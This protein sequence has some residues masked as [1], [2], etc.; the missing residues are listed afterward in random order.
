MST[1]E[2]RDGFA[3][4]ARTAAG[5][6]AGNHIL[7]EIWNEPNTV[8]FWGSEANAADYVEL[9]KVAAPGIKEADPTGLV[10][11]PCVSWLDLDWIEDCFQNGLLEWIDALSVHLYRHNYESPETAFADN[12]TQSNSL[13]TVRE[14]IRQYAPTGKENIPIVS[15]E[16][17]YSLIDWWGNATPIDEQTQARFLA[18]MYLTNLSQGIPVSI[19]YDWKNNGTDPNEREHNFGMVEADRTLKPAYVACQTLTSVLK[20][21]SIVGRMDTGD[22]EDFV[23]VLDK[24]PE[25]ALALWTMG[26][27]HTITLPME[28]PAGEVAVTGML[29]VISNLSWTDNSLAI[30]L[31]Q[32]PQYVLLNDA[33]LSIAPDHPKFSNEEF[34]FQLPGRKSI[35]AFL[36]SGRRELSVF[37]LLGRNLYGVPFHHGIYFLLQDARESG[38]FRLLISR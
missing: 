1:E 23:F 16:W 5:K 21:Y 29:G 8:R 20:G 33:L 30:V 34:T 12:P 19:W 35:A 36:P 37:D 26:E 11:G 14:L 7:W 28:P 13:A 24:G 6:Y 17:G 22:K 25:R 10:L 15:S 3:A 32:S 4:F 18:R 38:G 27:E 9:V 2:E 31:S